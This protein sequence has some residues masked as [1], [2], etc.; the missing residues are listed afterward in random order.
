MCHHNIIM[1]QVSVHVY[2]DTYH[3]ASDDQYRALSDCDV[4]LWQYQYRALSGCDVML[5]QYQ[6]RA[7]S[8]CDVWLWQ[9]Q[10]RALS[11][12]D[13]WL[14]QYEYTVKPAFIRLPQTMTCQPHIND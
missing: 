3:I 1:C 6:Y 2:S 5:C 7:L 8:G 13:V 4:W 14:W 11:T 10:Y 12:C 9:Y